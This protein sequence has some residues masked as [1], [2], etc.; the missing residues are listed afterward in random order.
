MVTDR[1]VQSGPAVF[2]GWF[3]VAGAFVVTFVGFGSAYTFSAFIESLQ[4]ISLRRAARLRWSS[5]W[6]ALCISPWASSADRLPTA[7]VP[8]CSQ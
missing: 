1:S 5:R 2:Y 6:P 8:V 7:S 4:R 3:V